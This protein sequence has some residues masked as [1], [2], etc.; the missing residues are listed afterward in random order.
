MQSQNRGTH[1]SLPPSD[2]GVLERFIQPLTH[3]LNNVLAAFQTFLQVLET[4]SP[5]GSDRDHSNLPAMNGSVAR[6][7][8]AVRHLR[9]LGATSY[10]DTRPVQVGPILKK[11]CS[12]FSL[13]RVPDVAVDVDDQSADS[14][15]LVDPNRLVQM[16]LYACLLASDDPNLNGRIVLSCRHDRVQVVPRASRGGEYGAGI[17]TV[18][19]RSAGDGDAD[20]LPDWVLGSA[21]AAMGTAR[22]DRDGDGSVL[23]E[24]SLPGGADTE[25]TRPASPAPADES[26]RTV[27]ACE[28]LRVLF[29]DDETSLVQLAQ[30]SFERLGCEVQVEGDGER[31]LDRFRSD[32][33]AFD[34]LITDQTMPGM[35]G[36]ELAS[37][38]RAVRQDMPVV[39]VTG[40]GDTSTA[41]DA[42]ALGYGYLAKPYTLPELKQVVQ[43]TVSDS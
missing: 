3:E 38:V 13:L 22:I 4:I 6:G 16:L 18:A 15:V 9:A 31:A 27:E 40:N 23:L 19:W 30:I 14:I 8:S 32:P 7:V 25:E 37:A 10:D 26:A 1:Q 20:R 12:L 2:A 11:V 28:P 33:R 34:I 42:A 5:G 21:A 17:V 43:A 41:A 24:I 29:V 39:I 35:S 36:G